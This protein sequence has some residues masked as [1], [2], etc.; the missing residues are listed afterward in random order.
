MTGK[1]NL[2][3]LIRGMRPVLHPGEFIFTSQLS[4]EN[5][6]L[7]SMVAQFRE[8][9]GI[10]VIMEKSVAD[11]LDLSYDYVASWITLK[12][13]SSLDAVGFTA[14]FSSELAKHSISCN[15]VAAYYHDHIFVNKKQGER[16][17]QVLTQLAKNY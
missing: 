11:D 6:P 13:H 2:S 14:I 10:T 8:K 12:I 1:S 3:E 17:V 5:I 7:E 16:A 9:E 4:L 15:V